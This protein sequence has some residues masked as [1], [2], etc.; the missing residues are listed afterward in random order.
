[1]K[2]TL[3]LSV[4]LAI[5]LQANASID[6]WFEKMANKAVGLDTSIV[7][8]SN[9]KYSNRGRVIGDSNIIYVTGRMLN[10]SNTETIKTIIFKYEILECNASGENCTTIGETKNRWDTNIPPKQARFFDHLIVQ[11]E[12][13]SGS[14]FYR[15]NI[16]YVYPYSVM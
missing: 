7:T 14:I 16:K 11:P 4:L 5:A 1:M 8:I 10:T 13:S 2:K 3:T 6:D 12:G 15:Q 9:L